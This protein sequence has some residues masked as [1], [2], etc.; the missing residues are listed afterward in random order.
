MTAFLRLRKFAVAR[1]NGLGDSGA[2]PVSRSARALQSTGTVCLAY[3]FF[4][5]GGRHEKELLNLAALKPATVVRGGFV[6]AM[7][8]SSEVSSILRACASSPIEGNS[9]CRPY[10][11]CRRFGLAPCFELYEGGRLLASAY[12]S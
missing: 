11:H 6:C 2:V 7:V 4:R 9:I 12:Q 1:N 8:I 3:L 5:S 10:H